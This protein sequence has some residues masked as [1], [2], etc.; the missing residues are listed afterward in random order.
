MATAHSTARTRLG[1]D[2]SPK[3][4]AMPGALRSFLESEQQFL[5]KSQSLLECIAH[6][7]EYAAQPVSGP[8]YPDVLELASDLIR[9]RVTN[10]DN[11]LLDGLLPK[12]PEQ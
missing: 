3:P 5:V 7:M 1:A 10:L 8:Y 9:Q 12:R 2:R 6:S 11:L 4:L